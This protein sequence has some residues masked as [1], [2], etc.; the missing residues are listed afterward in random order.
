MSTAAPQSAGVKDM[1][2]VEAT[3]HVHDT[4]HI[5]GSGL[6]SATTPYPWPCDAALAP[7]RLALLVLGWDETWWRR[8]V[9]PAAIV[10]TIVRLAGAVESVIVVHHEPFSP[11]TRRRLMPPPGDGAPPTLPGAQAVGA[12]G[13]DGFFGG[14]LDAV[15]RAQRRDLLLLVGLGLET[16]VHSTMRSAN[17]RGYECLLLVDACAPLD[18]DSVANARSMV[19]MSG[20]IFGAVGTTDALLAAL[21]LAAPPT[22]VTT[23]LPQEAA[24]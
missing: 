20:G 23:D 7:S 2:Q 15:L 4:G 22:D 24:S 17:D 18:P 10:P 16:T 11:S 8:S 5:E 12:A 13:F 9:R 3:G 19:E 1:D 21:D 6:V 14:P